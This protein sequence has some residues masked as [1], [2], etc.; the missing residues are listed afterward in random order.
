VRAVRRLVSGGYCC[1]TRRP[2]G[3][4]GRRRLPRSP[5]D[6]RPV[7][8]D[9]CQR[10]IMIR[11]VGTRTEVHP[12][13]I[14]AGGRSCVVPC[15]LSR[16]RCGGMHRRWPT[17]IGDRGSQITSCAAGHPPTARRRPTRKMRI[18]RA[19]GVGTPPA[20]AHASA[21][22]PIVVVAFS[23]TANQTSRHRDHGRTA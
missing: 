20:A 9:H 8:Q 7:V 4:T 23:S 1:V 2:C 21:K 18:R 3:P 10:P 15:L 14:T 16:C 17:I 13:V 11:H 5:L 12:V 22:K 6:T 19:D